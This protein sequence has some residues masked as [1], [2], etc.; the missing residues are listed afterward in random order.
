M[1]L[2]LSLQK[3]GAIMLVCVVM[4]AGLMTSARLK[5]ARYGSTPPFASI[6]LALQEL[7]LRT[8]Y[9]FESAL[10]RVSQTANAGFIFL[11]NQAD[12]ERSEKAH[13]AR[14]VPVLTYHRIVSNE[15]DLNNVTIDNFRD[16]MLTL[17]RAGW[18]T[19]TLK[20]YTEFL[21]GTR[22]LPERS[23]LITFDDG[24]KE[25]FYPVDPLFAALGYEGVMYVIAAAAHTPESVYY[26]SPVEIRRML[27]TERWEIGSHSYDGHRPYPS[28]AQ[29]SDGIFFADKLWRADGRLE[30]ED[31]FIE[32]VSNDLAHA[33]SALEEEYDVFVDSFA[34]PLGNETGIAGA[35][36]F[37]EGASIT[38]YAAS[39][40][41]TLGFLQTNNQGYTFNF[42]DAGFI[43][44][45]IHVDH[46]WNGE[47]LLREMEQG[48][49]KDIPFTDDFSEDRG[50]IPSW[51]S[52]DL[53]R[54]NMTL[55]AD[56]AASSAS[57]FLDG[58]QFWDN[59]SYDASLNWQNG[60]VFLLADVVHSKTYH[61]CAFSE[62]VVRVQ[63]TMDGETKVLAEKKDER[64][65]R[66][67]DRRLGIRVHDAVVECTWDYESLVEA[68]ERDHT[69]GIGIQVW[70]AELGTASLQVSEIL[71]RPYS[72]STQ[73]DFSEEQDNASAAS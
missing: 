52:L 71:V 41:Y 45:R 43:H 22:T 14:A 3:L 17:K 27:A 15:S 46:D 72:T 63:S 2:D 28:D 37:S 7:S 65:N 12:F 23:F 29:G 36:N 56:D 5:E 9:A 16:Q 53:G 73:S 69:G 47:R 51:G 35:A 26:L 44:R 34:F 13:M 21:R 64:I 38:E 25:S 68:Y 49:E 60:S 59:Y 57:T 33:R 8:W 18:E 6:G 67:N 1:Y 54:N 10:W 19:I 61:S 66:G 20:E 62:G 32:R 70:N 55:Q 48:L 31:E 4:F 40:L 42:P 50:W 30:T 11:K 58:S 24:A 39:R